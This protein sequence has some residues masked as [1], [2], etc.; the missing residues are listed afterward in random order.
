M[1]NTKR[2][3]KVIGTEIGF[4]RI[5]R[6]TGYL[7]GTIDRWNNSKRAEERDRIKHKVGGHDMN[8]KDLWNLLLAHKG[9]ELTVATYG[10]PGNPKNVSLECEDCN[11]VVL[12]AELYTVCAREDDTNE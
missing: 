3:K 11:E 12:D 6:I 2:D 10:D 7:V 9:H 8:N 5:R 4:E 1:N